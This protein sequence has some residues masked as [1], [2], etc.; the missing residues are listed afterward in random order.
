MD[1]LNKDS[2][3]CDCH[4]IK[5][6]VLPFT[7]IDRASILYDGPYIFD[8]PLDEDIVIPIEAKVAE[9]NIKIKKVPFEKQLNEYNGYTITIG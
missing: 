1:R 4:H 5:V 7:V 6:R 9:N 3:G 2:C 8:A